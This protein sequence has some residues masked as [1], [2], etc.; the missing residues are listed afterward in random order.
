MLA[1]ETAAVLLLAAD[2]V[3]HPPVALIGVSVIPVILELPALSHESV[4]EFVVFGIV[5]KRGTPRTA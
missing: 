3:V 4:Y 1:E 5:V 2:L